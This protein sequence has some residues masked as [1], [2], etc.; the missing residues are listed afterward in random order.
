MP[1]RCHAV[2]PRCRAG[3]RLGRRTWSRRAGRRLRGRAV[4]Q[5]VAWGFAAGR[6]AGGSRLT[7]TVLAAGE[8]MLAVVLLA[9]ERLVH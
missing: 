1:R 9:A 5:V 6:R 3:T 7:A 4:V 8:G 2:G